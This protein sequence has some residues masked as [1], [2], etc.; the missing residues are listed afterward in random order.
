MFLGGDEFGLAVASPGALL[1]PEQFKS[2]QAKRG[3]IYPCPSTWKFRAFLGFRDLHLVIYCMF[4]LIFIL[5]WLL[6][7]FIIVGGGFLV[8]FPGGFFNVETFSLVASS[9]GKLENCHIVYIEFL[10]SEQF[11]SAQAK[12]EL[13]T[14]GHV[15][16][17][18]N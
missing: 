11:K 1:S 17:T 15:C 5:I 7:L 6:L 18:K 14:F 8:E 16:D 9:V 2:A 10:N 3:G 12:R 13:H 4:Y